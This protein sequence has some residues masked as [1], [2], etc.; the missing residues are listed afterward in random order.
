VERIIQPE[1]ALI[2]GSKNREEHCYFNRTGSMKP[3]IPGQRKPKAAI[4]I[5][6]CHGNRARLTLASC[7]FHFIAQSD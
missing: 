3:P 4:D 6:Q 5:E 2:H 1:S 7:F